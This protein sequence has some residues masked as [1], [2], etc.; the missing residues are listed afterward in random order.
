MFQIYEVQ[1]IN[2]AV[3][4]TMHVKMQYSI[5]VDSINIILLISLEIITP[6]AHGSRHAENGLL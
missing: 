4:P 2:K 6:Y 5:S 1:S 3:G